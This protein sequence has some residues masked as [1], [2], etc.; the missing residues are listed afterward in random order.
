[1]PHYS[2]FT[3]LELIGVIL[4]TSIGMLGLA[5]MFGNT[6][7]ALGTATN[8]QVMAQYAQECAERVLE[9]RKTYGFNSSLIAATMCEPS[10]A[11]YTRTLSVPATY[12]G[13]AT[14]ACPSG[15]AC[16]DVT[17]TVCAGTTSPCPTGATTAT[18]TLMLV[19]Y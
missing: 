8:E 13:T 7:L 17:V 19:Q 15:I 11:S 4:L 2:G 12:L 16:R 9:T 14:S 10:P 5:K 6:E 1:M 18:V 3:L